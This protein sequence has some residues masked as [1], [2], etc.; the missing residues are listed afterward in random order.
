MDTEILHDPKHIVLFEIWEVCIPRPCRVFES[1]QSLGRG[2]GNGEVV[3]LLDTERNGFVSRSSMLKELL[4]LEPASTH[5]QRINI[6]IYVHFHMYTYA[7]I[8]YAH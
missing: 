3:A 8:T 4:S 2:M 6:S 5:P 7:K 1:S